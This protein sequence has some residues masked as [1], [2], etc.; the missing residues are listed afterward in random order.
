METFFTPLSI[1]ITTCAGFAVGAVWY[2]PLLFINAWM[3]GEGIIK[4]QLPKRGTGDV[5]KIQI[6]SFIAHGAMASVLAIIFD[7][8]SITSLKVAVSLGLL[9]AFGFI[10]TTRFVDMI[11]TVH[12]NHYEANSQARFLVA[13]GYYLVVVAVM[14]AT[15][16]LLKG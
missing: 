5:I 15:L 16:F 4:S 9:L 6:Y 12:G 1:F 7:L 2:S 11:Y 14:S 3:K 10:V 13:S 8:L